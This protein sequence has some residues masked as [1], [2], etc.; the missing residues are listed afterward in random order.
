MTEA[1]QAASSEL[2][3]AAVGYTER[4]WAI[5]PCRPRRKK[6]LTAH[7]FHDASV[8]ATVVREWWT[9]WPAA[10]IGVACGPSGL[11]VLDIDRGG[12][13]PFDALLAEHGLPCTFLSATGGGGNQ[14]VYR[15][16]P[17]HHA[18]NS[19]S[20]LGP[21]LDVRGDG[22]YVIA[23][24]SVH[25]SGER[26]AWEWYSPTIEPEWAPDCLLMPHAQPAAA[27][28]APGS[29]R[30]SGTPYGLAALRGELA[31]LA[32]T[33]EGARNHR[34][35]QAAFAIGQLVAGGE[36]D[37]RPA[38]DAL[39]RVAAD[40]GLGARETSRTLASGFNAGRRE[41]RGAS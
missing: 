29:A 10:N 20:K 7:G 22:G 19:A 12:L 31:A 33:P 8:S 26:Y 25:P 13:D 3:E 5:F 27:V 17:G 24:P 1:A 30:A 35:N 2:L 21:R 9:A 34:L 23:P 6:P 4:G 16:P 14:L 18:R 39:A 40:T 41:P 36:L 37:G 15:V 11:V 28:P 38:L 32:A